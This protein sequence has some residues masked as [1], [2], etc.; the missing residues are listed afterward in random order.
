MQFSAINFR[1]LVPI[2]SDCNSLHVKSNVDILSFTGKVFYPFDTSHAGIAFDITIAQN[3][4]DLENIEWKIDYFC[5]AGKE[6]ELRAWK[7]IYKIED[8]HKKHLR[9]NIKNWYK[10]YWDYMTDVNLCNIANLPTI[11]SQNCS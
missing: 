7:A 11:A 2:C 8:R 10:H 3:A 9:G 1:N 4:P 6:D 5:A